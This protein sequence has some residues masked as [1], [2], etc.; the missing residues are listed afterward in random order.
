[1]KY[2]LELTLSS[3]ILLFS[4]PVTAGGF[5]PP[6]TQ[7]RNDL[8]WL[9]DR[10]VIQLN[11]TTWPL[12]QET[13]ESALS[14][15]KVINPAADRQVIS[16]VKQR[17]VELKAP[18]QVNAWSNSAKPLLPAEFAA[19]QSSAYGAG[20]ILSSNDDYWDI[21]LQ[22]Q[23]ERHQYIDD[24]S[25]SNLNGSYVGIQFL[26][27]WLSF[28]EI[29]QW[30]G[31][32]N[33][34]STIRSDASRPVLGFIL[35]RAEQTPFE[36]PLLSWMGNW[37]YQISA[38]QLRQYQHPE[39]P[40]LLGGRL[41]IT[42]FSAF[43]LGASRMLMWGGKGRPNTFNSF[44]DALLGRDN[45]G[46]QDRDPGDQ[47][48]GMD[49]RLPLMPLIGLPVALYG[50][51][52][53]EDQAGILPS[54]NTF[55]AGIEGHHYFGIH[56]E[57]Q[58]N[59]YL[60]GV[61]TRSGMSQTGIIYYHY[62]YQQGYYQQGYPLGDAMGGD[63]TRYAS[64]MEIVFEDWQRVSTR[65]VWARVNPTSQSINQAFPVADTVRGLELNWGIPVDTVS[66][67]LGTWLAHSELRN[68]T[69]TGVN[70]SISWIAF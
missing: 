45:T 1:L 12:S 31:P 21:R 5:I 67:N 35:Q 36:S 33:D 14:K 19:R 60:E 30:W 24:L 69:S 61:N 32:G 53:G 28:G 43:E 63:G 44:G 10:E 41:T 25:E 8:S 15:A 23:I 37:Q 27:Q 65:L 58:F 7:I 42:P 40:K 62:C 13:I 57:K 3:A 11:L 6:D 48:G 39:D 18:L 2:S 66:M 47:L 46:S 29:D 34:G 55:I 20:G 22:G 38:G 17:M 68:K 54:H 59:W 26:N 70:I 50:Q 16:R 52:T 64:K 49:F 51:V 56:Q 9:A 4:F